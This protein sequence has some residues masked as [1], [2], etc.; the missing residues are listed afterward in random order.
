MQAQIEYLPRERGTAAR[1]A[2]T[3]A[4]E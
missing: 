3:A 2:F 4:A 1:I